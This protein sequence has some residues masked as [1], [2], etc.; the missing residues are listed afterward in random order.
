[1]RIVYVLNTLAVGGTERQVL[2]IA[3]RMA[4]RGHTVSLLVLR[5]READRCTTD[6]DVV[7]LDI[8]KNPASAIAGVRRAAA[9]VRSFHPDVIHGHNFHGN[10]LA[11]LMRLTCGGPKVI[12]T[13]HNV[14]EGGR[15]RMLAYRF[16]DR[17]AIVTT[18]VSG[19]VAERYMLLK[20]VSK[21]KI[22]VLTNGID[23]VEF[24][25]DADRRLALRR[26]MGVGDEFVWLSVGRDTTAKDLPNLLQAFGC[27][28]EA[29]PKA[30]LWIAG[31]AL[32]TGTGKVTCSPQSMPHGAM[33]CVR[34][35]G[36]RRDVPALLD[37]ADG[38]VLSSAWE[39]MPLALGEAMAMAKPVAAT[40]VG[41][42]REL[43]GETGVIVPARDSNALAAAML[44]IM[45]R[46][47]EE[48]AAMGR[49]A[50]ERICA[51]FS[52][53]VKVDEWE[54]LYRSIID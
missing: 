29:S 34:H 40:D 4:A 51:K 3:E 33:D 2:A 5:P 1:M 45:N 10:M 32:P 42:V 22:R 21:S 30:R 47:E 46:P 52:I 25:P 43:V 9:F 39:G 12:S 38:F 31:G 53:D 16:T 36:L 48:R 20:T 8:Q 11:R 15:S 27:V 24:A 17:L 23:A 35:L 49:T 14:Y 6:L 54:A 37:A 18:A 19:A 41:G 7:Y 13:I 50:R 28:W 44:R 26:E